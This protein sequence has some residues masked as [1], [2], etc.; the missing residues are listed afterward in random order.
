[1]H[2]YPRRS[3]NPLPVKR[4]ESLGEPAQMERYRL[5]EQAAA[6]KK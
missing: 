1:M 6:E 5:I 3:Y 2:L 4:P